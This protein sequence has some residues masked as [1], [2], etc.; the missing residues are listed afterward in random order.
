MTVLTSTIQNFR[1]APEYHWHLGV[2]AKRTYVIEGDRCVPAEA[3]E[4]LLGP[5]DEHEGGQSFRDKDTYGFKPATD[6]VVHGS[7]FSAGAEVTEITA[8]VEI[9]DLARRVRVHGDRRVETVSGLTAAFSRAAPFSSMPLSYERSYGGFDAR[10][11]QLL[12]DELADVIASLGVDFAD[13]SCF[14]Y[15]R[16][17]RGV[18]FFVAVETER[19][20]G[21]LLPNLE[22]PEDPLLPE[23]FFCPSWDRWMD[24]PIPGAL[25]WALP[26]DFPRCVYHDLIPEHTSRQRALREIALGALTEEDLAPTELLSPPRA[27]AANG[28]APGLSRVR[29]VGGEP[30]R[31]VH[32]HPSLRELVFRLPQEQP[33]LTIQPP[34]CPV[35]PLEAMLDTVHIEPDRGRLSL[36]WSGSLRVASRYPPDDL[37]QVKHMVKWT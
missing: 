31:L 35:L 10:A 13:A 30:V 6:V 28:A 32:L 34:G 25:D 33:E 19:A 37:A 4:R 5:E 8:S 26:S 12:G 18:G 23:H 24:Q 16:N 9:G 36:V 2:V 22:D 27:R 15:P 14:T 1:R 3:Q 17:A 7:A 20:V 11:A 29:L 21:T